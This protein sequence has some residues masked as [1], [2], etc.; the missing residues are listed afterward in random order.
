LKVTEAPPGETRFDAVAA[1]YEQ[2]VTPL[3][4]APAA[5]LIDLVAPQP[6]EAVLDAATGPGTAA[7]LAAP[8]VAPG[9]S[10]TGLDKSEAMLEIARQKADKEGLKIEFIQGDIEALELPD[11]SFD[12]VVSN[13]GL[14]TTEPARSLASI[15]RVLR[16]PDPASGKPGGRFALTHWGPTSPPAEAFYDLMRRRRVAEP[17]PRL[18]W[19]RSTDLIAR[20][21]LTSVKT[22]EALAALLREHGFTAVQ[23]SA[24]DYEMKYANSDAYLEMSLAFPLARAEFDAMSPGTQRMF[25]HELNAATAPF[26][27]PNRSILSRDTIL[28]A[29]ASV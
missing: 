25:R 4:R 5:D 28:F 29:V 24:R 17:G 8:R 27:G 3:F 16:S 26:R 9:G 10:V 21:W 23:A 11:A 7:L 15:R 6:G 22:P 18:E 14:G 19:L 2:H 1:A 13:F 20:P 12:V